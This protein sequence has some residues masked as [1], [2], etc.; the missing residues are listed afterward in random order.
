MKTQ[1]PTCAG[2]GEI[3]IQKENGEEVRWSKYS[4]DKD[5]FEK[6]SH[7][8]I[9]QGHGTFSPFYPIAS[10]YRSDGDFSINFWG[11]GGSWPIVSPTDI[12]KKFLFLERKTGKQGQ[13]EEPEQKPFNVTVIE[14]LKSD[15]SFE[16]H[17]LV[18]KVKRMGFKESE[19]QIREIFDE[20]KK[21]V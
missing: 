9:R 14:M 18:M 15:P 16:L 5:L 10:F 2:S 21:S 12:K 1:C 6:Y 3:T 7:A 19:D 8:A 20:W 11:D 17:H 4:G 13:F